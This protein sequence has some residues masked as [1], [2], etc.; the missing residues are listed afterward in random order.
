MAIPVL[1]ESAPFTPAQ[2]AWLNGFLAGVLSLDLSTA[3]GGAV[4]SPASAGEPIAVA[5]AEEEL[6]WHDPTLPI[7]VRLALA[8]GQP[9]ARQLMAAMAQLD[10]GTCGYACKTYAEAIDRGEEQS[11]A[12]CT[13][14]GKET[15]RKLKQIMAR[16]AA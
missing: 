5:A 13:P 10:C 8:E 9:R 15:A 2:R 7:D 14:G 6:P 12:K 11:L 4:Q 16:A 3:M 1:P